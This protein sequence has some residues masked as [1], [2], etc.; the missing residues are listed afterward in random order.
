MTD[1]G[2]GQ[3]PQG[4]YPPT[5][6]PKKRRGAI[7]AIVVG[8]LVLCGL[9]ACAAIVLGAGLFENKTKKAVTLAE[10]HYSAAMSAVETASAAIKDAPSDPG[11][12]A[13]ALETADTSLR[14]GRDEI[15]AARAAI[16][17]LEDSDGKK[18]YLASLA[19][20]NTAL[21]AL[22]DMIAYLNDASGMISKVQEA[23]TV[24]SDA[25][26]E[27]NT[28]ISA[29]NRSDYSTMKAK[30]RSASADYTKAAQLFKEAHK[31]DPS[32][33]LD[34]AAAYAAKRKEQAVLVIR[35]ADEGAAEKTSAYN[36]DID[37]M[38]A[39]GDQA[40]RIGD[41]AIV[42]DPQWAQKRLSSLEQ[43]ISDSGAQADA[44]HAVALKEFGLVE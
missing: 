29:G 15:A 4:G 13:P 40:E 2:Y 36:G 41:P 27:L 21:D 9:F 43:R 34:K 3:P 33:G 16:E 37:R 31:L 7:V 30:A 8:A 5:P 18:Q 12:A 10:S 42:S 22:Q 39:L 14:T 32:A 25:N 35:M 1:G 6:P 23:G 38:K 44:L 11:K 28:A 17:P 19:A 24:A 20:A 26:D